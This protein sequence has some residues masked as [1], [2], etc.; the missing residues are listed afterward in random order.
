MEKDPEKVRE[1]RTLFGKKEREI[2]KDKRK[3]KYIFNYFCIHMMYFTE[4]LIVRPPRE[5]LD[6]QCPTRHR[7]QLGGELLWR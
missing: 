6:P 5:R 2:E 4:A 1:G 7:H 3:D